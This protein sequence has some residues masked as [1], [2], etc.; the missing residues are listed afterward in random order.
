ML[1]FIR[2]VFGCGVGVCGTLVLILVLVLVLSGFDLLGGKV[3]VWNGLHELSLS[4]LQESIYVLS[5]VLCKTRSLFFPV[6]L[7]CLKTNT[8]MTFNNKSLPI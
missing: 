6:P 8:H 7:R 2:P 5:T 1:S 3:Q 4:F